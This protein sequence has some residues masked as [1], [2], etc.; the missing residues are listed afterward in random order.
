MLTVHSGEG[1]LNR[2]L[3]LF[4]LFWPICAYCCDVQLLREL[5]EQKMDLTES[6]DPVA[7][8]RQWLQLQR[9]RAKAKKIVDTR[10]SKGRKIR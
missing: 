1:I 10:A 9:L 8:G 2:Q 5:I 3:F 7:M 6:S 4:F